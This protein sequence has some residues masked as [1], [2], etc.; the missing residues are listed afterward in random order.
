MR[1][2]TEEN[3]YESALNRLKEVTLLGTGAIE[4]KSGYGLNLESEIQKNEFS[5][6]K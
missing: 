2:T 4:I 5:I 3:L 6:L 1:N